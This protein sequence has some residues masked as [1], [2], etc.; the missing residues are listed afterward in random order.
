MIHPVPFLIQ[1]R[2]QFWLA[3]CPQSGWMDGTETT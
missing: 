3:G 2:N 1:G